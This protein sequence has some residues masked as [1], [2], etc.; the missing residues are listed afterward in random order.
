MTEEMSD[1]MD[2]ARLW[3][4]QVNEPDFDDW[5]G[6]SDWL[7]AD[8]RHLVAYE[9]ALDEDAWVDGV[10]EARGRENPIISSP[11]PSRAVL[12]RRRRWLGIGGAIAAAVAG[13]GTW[14]VM[15]TMS[16]ETEI[17]TQPGERRSIALSDGT[18]VAINGDSSINYDP[19]EPRLVTLERGEALFEVHHDAA[20]PFVVMVGRTR[21]IDAGTVF[22]VVREGGALEVAV[23]EGAVIYDAKGGPIQLEPGDALIRRGAN[24]KVELLKADPAAVGSWR[25]DVLPYTKAPLSEIARDLSRNLGQPVRIAPGSEELRFSGTLSVDGT[26]QEV[27]ARTGPLLGVTFSK[28]ADGWEMLPTDGAPR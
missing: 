1:L 2:T 9:T 4:I 8:S 23:A 13:I 24:A 28:T 11:G 26:A 19:D 6:L 27:M 22:N 3:M 20:K 17:V 5:D 12:A 14:T 10:V 25:N 15:N 21:L 16:V 18:R 7:E